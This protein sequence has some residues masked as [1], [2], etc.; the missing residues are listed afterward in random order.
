MGLSIFI[1]SAKAAV[2]T[3]LSGLV[4]QSSFRPGWRYLNAACSLWR[5]G[6]RKG[7]IMGLF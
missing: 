3:L 5:K 6:S 7:T 2:L 1:S 4:T